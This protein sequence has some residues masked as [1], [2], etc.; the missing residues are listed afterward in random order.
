MILLF[1]RV[2]LHIYNT[3]S[4]VKQGTSYEAKVFGLLPFTTYHI[5]IE[6]ANS[7]GSVSSGLTSVQTWEAP[8]SGLNN[9]TVEKKESG[10][11]LLL[12]WSA[13]E[14][15]NGILLVCHCVCHRNNILK[16]PALTS[17]LFKKKQHTDLYK[18]LLYISGWG[19]IGGVYVPCFFL[20]FYKKKLAMNL[21]C[22]QFKLYFFFLCKYNFC[23]ST[24][25][26]N[27]EKKIA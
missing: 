5:C 24:S 2:Y 7:A 13:P 15:T 23:C 4:S 6:A 8:P 12:Q 1:L 26:S 18:G 10:R 3:S 20:F 9:F 14:R 22:W 19:T 17:S 27:N 16:L 21:I 25:Y 11:A